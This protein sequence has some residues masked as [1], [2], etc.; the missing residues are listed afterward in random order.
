MRVQTISAVYLVLFRKGPD[1][2][3]QVLMAQRFNTGY[4]DGMWSLPAGH[5]EANEPP[6]VGMAREAQEEINLSVRPEALR[7]LHTMWRSASDAEGGRIDFFLGPADSENDLDLTTIQNLEPNKCSELRW[8][9]VE[10]LPENTIEDVRKCL[11]AINQ[12]ITFQEVFKQ[13]FPSHK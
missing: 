6:S 4:C 12:G 2:L 10:A 9:P 13:V 3:K 5:L 11:E 8:W 1:G 7:V